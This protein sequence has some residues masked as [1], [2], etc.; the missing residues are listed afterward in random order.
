[1]HQEYS[2]KFIHVFGAKMSSQKLNINTITMHGE[3]F[4]KHSLINLTQLN[5]ESFLSSYENIF[6]GQTCIIVSAG[7]S[8]TKQLPMLKELQHNVILMAVGQT[9]KTL[10]AYGIN[11]HFVTGVDPWM[12]PW[13]ESDGYTD[14][15]LICNTVFDPAAVPRVPG[16]KIFANFTNEIDMRMTPIIGKMGSVSNGGSVANFSY[17]VAKFMGFKSIAFVG[18]DLAYTGG[19]S[20]ASGYLERE[21]RSETQ[22]RTE[23]EM[24]TET[25]MTE[26]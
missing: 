12:L 11:P 7:P 5:N 17:S 25:K 3:I 19:I 9:I 14:E 4:L 24:E 18:Q 13:F 16:N 15:V 2:K 1:L 8:L 23:T 20:H 26:T 6:D 21:E 22:T 10:H